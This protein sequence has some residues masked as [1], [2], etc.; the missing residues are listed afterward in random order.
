MKR[1]ELM[2]PI[3]NFAGLEACKD[4]A[5]AVYFGIADFSLRSRAADI[6][7]ENLAEFVEK[8]LKI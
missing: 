8:K 2:V 4:Y 5:D 3:K 7:I 6:T 1:P